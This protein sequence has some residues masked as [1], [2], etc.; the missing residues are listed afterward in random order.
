MSV[1]HVPRQTA[2]DE[3]QLAIPAAILAAMLFFLVR[4]WY[5]QVIRADALAAQG[6][7]TGTDTIEQL[8]PRGRI[9][10]RN[11][12]VL[13]GVQ[14]S[15]V[16]TA[17]Y[18]TVMKHPETIDEVAMLIGVPREK[19][20]KP[21]KEASWDPYVPTTIYAGI[22][23]EAASRIAEAG[24]R[25]PGF[26]C[27]MQPTR[28]YEDASSTSHLLGYVWKPTEKEVKALRRQGLEAAPYVGRD[29][30]EQVY[31]NLLMGQPGKEKI[32]VDPQMRPIRTIS[33]DRAVPGKEL[34][35]SIDLRLQRLGEQL[36][37]GQKGA[38]VALD[39]RN[40]E[41]LCLVSSPSYDIHMFDHGISNADYAGLKDNPEL[42]M[43]KRPIAGAYPPGSTFKVVTSTA[44]YLAGVFDPN[45]IVNCPGYYMVG[46]KMYHCM[47]AHGPMDYRKAVTQ[48]CNTY[49]YDLAIRAGV[50]NLREA[51]RILGLGEK[52]GIDL[53]GESA[54]TVPTAEWIK[55][56]KRTW[57][58]GQTANMGIGQGQLAITPLQMAGV[59]AAVANGGKVYRPHLLLGTR[60]GNGPISPFQAQV[61]SDTRLPQQ[62][63]DIVKDALVNVINA[64]TAT[65]AKIPDIQWGGKTGS[66]QNSSSNTTHSWFIGF[67]PADNPTIAIAVVVEGAG[68]GGTY[69]APFAKE[70]VQ[71]YLKGNL[72]LTPDV[73]SSVRVVK[74]AESLPKEDLSPIPP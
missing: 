25:L 54:G 29:G 30:V 21:L 44:A 15:A 7:S 20:D 59:A 22:S 32:A 17:V 40:G 8:A 35:L 9:V 63:W 38:I 19:L 18:D 66:A 49:F 10:D 28:V 48:S 2:L 51:C 43:F 58:L 72:S 53:P 1:I 12:V 16:L 46:T 61:L 69:A 65:S 4:L 67:A 64:G 60:I 41:V 26:N 50:D 73:Q 39:P 52:Q 3:R 27:L 37:Q 36:L 24:D 56:K 6:V 57:T 45:R 68:H 23:P 42:P 74:I 47:H 11:G 5:V 33:T 62:F 71:R 55:K 14:Q 70:I 31:E 13:A 34:V